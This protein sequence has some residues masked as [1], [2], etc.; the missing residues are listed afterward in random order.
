MSLYLKGRDLARQMRKH[1]TPAEEFF[2]QKVRNRK[3]FGLKF[4]RQYIVAFPF[5]ATFTKF[6]IADFY[7]EELKLIIGLDGQIHLKVQEQDLI[8]TEQMIDRGYQVLRFNNNEVLYNWD[9]IQNK[10]GSFKSASL[11]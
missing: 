5:D 3:L 10:I 9:Y 1:A 11:H 7:C 6:Y 8:R 2:W 4:Q